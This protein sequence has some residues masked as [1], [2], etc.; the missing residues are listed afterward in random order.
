MQL[1]QARGEIGLESSVRLL[2][3]ARPHVDDEIERRSRDVTVLPEDLPDHPLDPIPRD[4]MAEPSRRRDPQ[5]RPRGRSRKSEK[6]E[7]GSVHAIP[8]LVDSEE[9]FAGAEAGRTPERAVHAVVRARDACAPSRGAGTGQDAPP[10]CSCARGTRGSS[11]A[12]GYSVGTC[13]SSVGVL[14]LHGESKQSREVSKRCQAA[15]RRRCSATTARAVET[16]SF[17]VVASPRVGRRDTRSGIHTSIS[18]LATRCTRVGE[19][20]C[21]GYRCAQFPCLRPATPPES[22][23][24]K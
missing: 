20:G 19:G 6:H 10:W 8:A 13:A 7:E 16:D 5:A 12:G 4:G 18:L 11:C 15:S 3:G 1:A 14:E 17:A 22:A 2:P 24:F 21:E 23:I 9:L